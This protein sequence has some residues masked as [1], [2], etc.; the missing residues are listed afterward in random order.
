MPER[1]DPERKMS[2]IR[3]EMFPFPIAILERY[4]NLTLAG[5][6]MFINGICFINTISIH[7][8]FMTAEYIAN[9]EASTLQE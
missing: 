4:K 1:K 9:K 5:D 2:H 8:K 6:I 7:V 3:G